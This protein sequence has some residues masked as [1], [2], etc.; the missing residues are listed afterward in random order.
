MGGLGNQIKTVVLLGLLSGLLL[1]VGRLIGGTT[2]LFVALVFSVLMNF[3][4]F[5]FSDK[6]VLAMYRAKP[7][8]KK[9]HAHL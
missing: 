6:I 5:W 1:I 7:A 8:D 4:A 9:T 3:G 2:G